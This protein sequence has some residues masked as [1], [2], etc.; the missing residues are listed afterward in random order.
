M[1]EYAQARDFYQ[2]ALSIFIEFGDRFS[3]ARTYH[4]LGIVAQEM[5]EYAQARDFYQ[6]ALAIK[7]EFGDF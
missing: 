1:R 5:R 2:L 7:I 6:L 3:Q 4:N